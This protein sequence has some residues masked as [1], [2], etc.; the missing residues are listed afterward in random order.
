MGECLWYKPGALLAC[1]GRYVRDVLHGAGDLKN[2]V[3][4]RKT[5]SEPIG[6]CQVA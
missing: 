6:E 4:V 1:V 3:V 2:G 5:G